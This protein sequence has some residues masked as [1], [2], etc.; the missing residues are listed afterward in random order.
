[1]DF[2][3]EAI[4]ALRRKLRYKVWYHVGGF[5]P[6]VEDLVQESILRLLR[7][8][9]EGS[10]R[11]PESIGPF[12]SGICHNVILEYRRRVWRDRAEPSEPSEA[13]QA[14]PPE[15]EALELRDA[16]AAA[17]RELSERDRRVLTA[18]FVEDRTAESICAETGMSLNQFRV[19]LCRAKAR[20]RKIY[21]DQMKFRAGHGH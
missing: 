11:K 15:A 7:A 17:M 20:F 18:F 8:L 4:D 2:N 6:D 3:P 12:L 13:A 14:I 1:M 9:N 19:C 5:C 10:I 16:I 21:Q